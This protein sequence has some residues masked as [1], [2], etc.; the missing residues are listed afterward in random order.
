MT[1]LGGITIGQSPRVDITPDLTPLLPGVELLE[2]GA[3]D[4]LEEEAL[5]ALRENPHGDVLA[6]RLRDGREILVGEED[7]IPKVQRAIEEL[8]RQ[9]VAAILLLCTGTFPKFACEVPLLYPERVLQAAVVAT[10]PGGALG[11]ITPYAEQVRFQE[12]RWSSRLGA[13]VLVEAVSPYRAHWELELRKAAQRLKAAGVT[14]IVLDCLGY[15]TTMRA[16][17]RELAGVPVLLART[18]LGR[19]A[20]EFAG[21]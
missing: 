9:D 10:F 15:S 16:C 8:A 1:R 5:R 18:T 17:V 20:A 3:L 13:E 7:V 21:I 19:I 14:M 12:A 11:V 4:D 6:T 2:R